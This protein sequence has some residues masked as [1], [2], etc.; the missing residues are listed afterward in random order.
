[1]EFSVTMTTCANR[2]QAETLAE[3]II[4]NKLAACVQISEISSV[5]E[6]DNK[7]NKDKEFLLLIKGRKDLFSK[8]RDYVLSNHSYDVPELILLDI[9][10]GNPKYLDW[11]RGG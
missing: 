7:L 1:M 5:Y 9:K 4:K 11:M 10:D 3:G 8:L 6:W 2:E